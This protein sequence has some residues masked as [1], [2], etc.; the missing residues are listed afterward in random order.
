MGPESLLRPGTLF[1][2]AWREGWSSFPVPLRTYDES[3][4]LLR[5][6]L[7]GARLGDTRKMDCFPRLDHLTRAVEEDRDPF[8]DFGPPRL[9]TSERS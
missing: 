3:L 5:R 9:R 1:F 7:E 4:A 6:P 8:A 2:C